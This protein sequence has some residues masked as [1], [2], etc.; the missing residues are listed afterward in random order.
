M[1]DEVFLCLACFFCS[2][3][4]CIYYCLHF[5]IVTSLEQSGRDEADI[6]G[7]NQSK[8]M[9]DES[10]TDTMEER[11]GYQCKACNLWDPS[12]PKRRDCF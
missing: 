6:F 9:S 12:A 10:D 11:E 4:I 5:R 8:S 7:D 3:Y 2:Q 1:K